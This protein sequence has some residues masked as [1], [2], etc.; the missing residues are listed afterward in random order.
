MHKII[1]GFVSVCTRTPVILAKRVLSK[2]ADWVYHRN[3]KWDSHMQ[4]RVLA[5][6]YG[7]MND[8]LYDSYLITGRPEHLVAAHMFDEQPLFRPSE[9]ARMYCAICRPTPQF[10][11]LSVP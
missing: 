3:S 7:G 4:A 8:C 6:E 10:P 5:V 9:L 2:L 1:E 11:S